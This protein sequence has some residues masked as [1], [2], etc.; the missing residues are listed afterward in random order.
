MDARTLHGL[1]LPCGDRRDTRALIWVGRR[2]KRHV[3]G[4]RIE[5]VISESDD[6]ERN[7]SSKRSIRTYS[8]IGTAY[9][10]W[11]RANH[12]ALAGFMKCV[13]HL[14]LSLHSASIAASPCSSL[15]SSNRAVARRMGHMWCPNATAS[16][17]HRSFS[18]PLY[19]PQNHKHHYAL[20]MKYM[21][22]GNVLRKRGPS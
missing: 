2:S 18:F 20:L 22:S 9:M 5:K 4:I 3:D 10:W 12:I 13:R 6:G 8:T 7:H 11:L 19:G 16:L 15:V 14:R 1:P 17:I 21:C